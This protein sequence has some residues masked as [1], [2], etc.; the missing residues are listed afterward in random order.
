[1]NFDKLVGYTAV[2]DSVYFRPLSGDDVL[3][4]RC[5]P[6]I[7]SHAVAAALNAS[8]NSVFTVLD[9]VSDYKI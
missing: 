9:A 7:D 2:G 3:V 4:L 1:M 5:P 6:D 8:A